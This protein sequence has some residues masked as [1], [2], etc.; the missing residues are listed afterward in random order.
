MKLN[1]HLRFNDNKCKEALDFYKKC[2]GKADIWIQTVGEAS[3]PE[4]LAK[5]MPKNS[6][7]KIMHANFQAGDLVF[8]ASD[9]MMDKAVVGDNISLM[10]NCDSEKQLRGLFDKLAE[11][12]EVFLPVE[13]AFWGAYFGMVTDKYG[14]E[15]NLNFPIEG[16]AMKK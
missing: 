6:D 9:M 15:W 1:P 10:V 2:F 13:K 14:I 4:D 7:N 16:E 5:D 12:G 8:T 3:I 11:G